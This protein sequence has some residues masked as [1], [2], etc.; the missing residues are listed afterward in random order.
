MEV[1]HDKKTDPDCDQAGDADFVIVHDAA[2][3]VFGDGAIEDDDCAA[4]GENEKT[5]DKSGK[6]KT[7]RIII[8]RKHGFGKRSY[9]ILGENRV[10]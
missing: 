4:S 10:K 9:C 2:R 7:H 1:G 5:D 3:N 8:Y 6:A